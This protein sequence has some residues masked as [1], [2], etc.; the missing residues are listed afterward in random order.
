MNFLISFPR[1]GQHLTEC[2]LSYLCESHGIDYSYCEYYKCCNSTPCKKGSIFQKNHDF[3]IEKD[4]GMIINNESKYLVLF[5]KDPILQLESYYRYILSNKNSNSE[6]YIS[7]V[8]S[9]E[10][11]DLLKFV[12]SKLPYYNK[13]LEKWINNDKDNILKVEYYELINNVEYNSQRIFNHFYP[14]VEIDRS[15]LN[16]ISKIEFYTFTKKSNLGKVKI[17]N[18]INT[19][20]YES[21]KIDLK[22]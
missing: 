17:K 5:R 20:I 21:L 6:K 22:L 12:K 3:E 16:E 10:Y 2:I 7:E 13:F 14:E 1:S 11:D 18:T 4:K 9:Y 8:S 19:D 15:K